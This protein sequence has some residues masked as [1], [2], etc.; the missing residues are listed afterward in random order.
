MNSVAELQKI[1]HSSPAR[2]T[3]NS[4]CTLSVNLLDVSFKMLI[5]VSCVLHTRQNFNQLSTIVNNCEPEHLGW[6]RWMATSCLPDRMFKR[7][8]YQLASGGCYWGRKEAPWLWGICSTSSYDFT[9]WLLEHEK[10]FAFLY[11]G[12]NWKILVAKPSKLR[13]NQTSTTQTPSY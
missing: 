8:L 4:S 2:G 5:Q 12:V 9:E 10:Q 11:F 7:S 13:N 3:F 6:E 1:C